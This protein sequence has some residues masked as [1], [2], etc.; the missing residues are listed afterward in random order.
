MDADYCFKIF[1]VLLVIY[2]IF[3]VILWRELR[4]RRE[5]L[6]MESELSDIQNH[7][8]D[9]KE[10]AERLDEVRR[11]YAAEARGHR[12]SP[13]KLLLVEERRAEIARMGYFQKPP[14]EPEPPE[15]EQ[16]LVLFTL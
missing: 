9:T 7:P 2:A 8:I 11:D 13:G 14:F 10:L 6:H 1:A 15:H 4:W 16:G 3:R 5:M 12:L